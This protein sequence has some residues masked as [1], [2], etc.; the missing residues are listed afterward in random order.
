MDQRTDLTARNFPSAEQE[1]AAAQPPSRYE[2]P[3]SAYRLAF[4]DTEFLLRG[5]GFLFGAREVA[6]GEVGALI[7]ESA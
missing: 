5:G 1:A 2:G 4:A 7:H 3:E 6:R